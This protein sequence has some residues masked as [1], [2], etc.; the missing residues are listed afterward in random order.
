MMAIEPTIDVTYT[1]KNHD[2]LV[3]DYVW[4]ITYGIHL[5]NYIQF[6]DGVESAMSAA[7]KAVIE[8]KKRGVS[9]G[10]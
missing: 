5:V 2:E 6:R 3:F 10:K 8:Y 7:D 9:N 4:L 1:T